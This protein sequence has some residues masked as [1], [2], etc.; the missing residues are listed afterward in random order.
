MSS[1]A[2]DED[3]VGHRTVI[4]SGYVIAAVTTAGFGLAPPTPAN[5][6]ILFVAS[7]LYIACEEVAEQ[8]YAGDLLP[9]QTRGTG[10]G[11]LAAVNGVGDMISSAMVGVRWAIFASSP[12]VG[13][14][15]AASLRLAGAALVQSGR[16]AASEGGP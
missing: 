11:L 3:C 1:C 8:A 10:L 13:F 4:V 5:L 2:S 16:P 12:A 9:H 15:A 14:M 6:A 7:G